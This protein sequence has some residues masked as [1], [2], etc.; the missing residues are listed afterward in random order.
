MLRFACRVRNGSLGVWR[1][2]PPRPSA[3]PPRQTG[4]CH[5]RNAPRVVPEVQSFTQCGML[6]VFPA[7]HE[8]IENE[9]HY[10]RLGTCILNGIKPRVTAPIECDQFTVNGGPQW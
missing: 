10:V 4:S 3:E 1:Q 7:V 9:E 5:R 6:N 8:N 2:H